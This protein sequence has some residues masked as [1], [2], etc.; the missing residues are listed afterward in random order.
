[1]TIAEMVIYSTSMMMCFLMGSKL[2]Q[3]VSEVK[4]TKEPN[5]SKLNP[6]KLYNEHQEKKKAEEELNRLDS[7]LKNVERY[8]GTSAGQEDVPNG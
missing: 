1:M 3:R 4:E 5:L 6:I 7:I 8:D 2:G